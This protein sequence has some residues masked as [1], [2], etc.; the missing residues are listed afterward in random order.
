MGIARELGGRRN[1]EE[2]WQIWDVGFGRGSEVKRFSD[3]KI[4]GNLLV[5]FR[6]AVGSVDVSG[7]KS[8]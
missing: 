6:L 2:L 1:W 8:C 7:K 5:G 3:R 4:V